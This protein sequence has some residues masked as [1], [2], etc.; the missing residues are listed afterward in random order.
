VQ[1]KLTFFIFVLI[2]SGL[3]GASPIEQRLTIKERLRISL[4]K[5]GL[6]E[7]SKQVKLVKTRSSDLPEEIERSLRKL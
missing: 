5:D 4:W 2:L 3:A 7:E 1:I 6:K